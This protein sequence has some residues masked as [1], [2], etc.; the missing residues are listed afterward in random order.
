MPVQM[1]PGIGLETV[2][3]GSLITLEQAGFADAL[4]ATRELDDEHI[5]HLAESNPQEWPPLECVRVQMSDKI[6]Y[7]VIDGRHRWAALVQRL[8]V[9]KPQHGAHVSVNTKAY[10]N[11]GDVIDAAFQANLKHG[12]HASTATRSDYAIWLYM[13]DPTGKPNMT[14]IAH[15]VGLNKSTVSRA[16]KRYEEG[17][18]EGEVSPVY[19]EEASNAQKLI[20]ALR[21]FFSQERTF[22]GRFGNGAGQRDV[23]ARANALHN[24]ILSRPEE[25]HAQ[26]MQELRSLSETLARLDEMVKSASTKKKELVKK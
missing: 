5:E 3:L 18:A 21:R 14:A 20:T 22:L 9:E 11:E 10:A 23:T 1:L 26:I 4:W 17:Q 24:F 19:R 15:K 2:P 7:A 16:L 13:H 8:Q 25:N 6:G 12:L